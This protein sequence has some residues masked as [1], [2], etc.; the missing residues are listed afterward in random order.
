[1]D[2][3]DLDDLLEEATLHGA[4]AAGRDPALAAHQFGAGRTLAALA[5][6]PA[7]AR[8][9]IA[10]VWSPADEEFLRQ[11]A[12]VLGDAEIAE[13]LG[14]SVTAVDLRRSRLR[15]PGPLTHPDYITANRMALALGVDA[16]AV[17]GWIARGIFPAAEVAPL[18]NRSFV[19]RARRSA[20]Y[21]WALR[22][23]NWVYFYR[24]VRRPERIRDAALRRLIVRRAAR[25]GDEWWTS[26]EV[27]AYHDVDSNDVQRYIVAGRL[28]AARWQNWMVR[29]SDATRPGLRFF[30]GKGEGVFERCGTPAG[31]A[32]IVLTAA[33]GIPA[34]HV[35]RMMGRSSHAAASERLK[36]ILRRGHAPWLIR[37]YGL[38]VLYRARPE[39]GRYYPDGSLW[40]DWRAVAHRFPR[41]S[42][43]WPQVEAGGLRG[44]D[45]MNDLNLV[46]G[47]LRAAVA[48]N[49]G[50]EHPLMN[51][52]LTRQRPAVAEALGLWRE[53]V[54]ATAF[55]AG[56]APREER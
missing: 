15:L 35:S 10:G 9:T 18:T 13:R 33:V 44:L 12:G 14:R 55:P 3:L 51:R 37:A 6:R 4:L 41:L 8:A 36:H 48:W 43:A 47:V 32:F 23:E 34:T 49:L 26:G 11:W 54:E 25:W 31:D 53:W 40:A 39:A 27:A 38:P 50:R 45:E 5:D 30:K 22:P 20:F 24:S 1:M 52:L 28:P 7:T 42:Q 19:W 17:Y 2:S 29:R 56:R 16:K 46:M 21:A